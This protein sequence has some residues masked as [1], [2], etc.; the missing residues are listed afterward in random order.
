LETKTKGGD[1]A[2]GRTTAPVPYGGKVTKSKKAGTTE[3]GKTKKNWIS[4]N[5]GREKREKKI[6]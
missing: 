1:P 2:K 5:R 6:K 3:G 4:H